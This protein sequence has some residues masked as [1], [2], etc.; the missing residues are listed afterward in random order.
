[1]IDYS[2]RLAN[3]GDREDKLTPKQRRRLK[4]KENRWV[5]AEKRTRQLAKAAARR[6]R[7]REWLKGFFG[8]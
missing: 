6:E 4:H 5:Y 7:R 8:R 2:K 3:Y 1:V